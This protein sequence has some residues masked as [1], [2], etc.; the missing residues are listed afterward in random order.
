MKT[1]IYILILIVTN[2]QFV[3]AELTCIG[4]GELIFY[5][6]Y[7]D[8]VTVKVIPE[9]SI[10][11][12][13]RTIVGFD[14]KY[15]LRPSYRTTNSG[16]NWTHVVGGSRTMPLMSSGWPPNFSIC[17]CC[18]QQIY[19]IN[20]NYFHQLTTQYILCQNHINSIRNNLG[21]GMLFLTNNGYKN[22]ILTFNKIDTNDIPRKV[23]IS[24][25]KYNY[26][27]Y[28]PINLTFEWINLQNNKDS[29]WGIFGQGN[30]FLKCFVEDEKGNKFNKKNKIL[31]SYIGIREPEYV[32]NTNDTLRRS[33]TINDY[34]K[35]IQSRAE[36]YFGNLGY[37]PAGK[38]K[39]YFIIDE[40][41]GKKFNIPIRTNEIE[42]EI[43][44]I[45]EFDSQILDL[46]RDKKYD[47]AL[48]LFPNYNYFNEYLK[49]FNLNKYIGE[50]LSD[51]FEHKA[52]GQISTLLAKY[53]D[54]FK[55]YHNSQY[56]LNDVFIYHYL[57][58]GSEEYSSLLS[59]ANKLMRM[60]PNTL[61]EYLLH[62]VSKRE[63]FNKIFTNDQR[64]F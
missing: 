31:N 40:D 26:K 1:F 44:E 27:S 18:H 60:Y 5:N 43:S 4:E 23:I 64:L 47:V 41:Y 32:L 36:F 7:R 50:Y 19:A 20:P 38:Y 53:N 62:D 16:T 51:K 46:V 34:A 9:G 55:Q 35:P 21:G 28:E 15:S 37:F 42:F 12:G 61:I 56:I 25:P 39:L 11:S 2:I 54:F 58:I 8:G 10:F 63:K 3:V 48:T 24:L 13:T 29:I 6:Y 59:K 45:N 33:I 52:Y 17:W 14:H 30:D 57:S 22:N 49:Y